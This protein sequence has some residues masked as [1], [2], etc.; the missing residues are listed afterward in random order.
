MVGYRLCFCLESTPLLAL[1][2]VLV[3]GTTPFG[4]VSVTGSLYQ[5][6]MGGRVLICHM[7]L[8]WP[9]TPSQIW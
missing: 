1:G 3:F 7:A 6:L 9:H 4:L 5:V 8:I 2:H